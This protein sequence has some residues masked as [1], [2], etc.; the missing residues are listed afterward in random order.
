M[1]VEVN[2]LDVIRTKRKELNLSLSK[3]AKKVGCSTTYVSAVMKKQK[4]ASD[5][6]LIRTL[7][8]LGYGPSDIF[9]W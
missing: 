8:A 7:Y 5:D 3:L 4:T 1:T 2:I 6:F 9:L